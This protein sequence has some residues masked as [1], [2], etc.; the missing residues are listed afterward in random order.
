MLRRTFLYNKFM[1][2][3]IMSRKIA[4]VILAILLVATLLSP[5]AVAAGTDANT[6]VQSV[7]FHAQWLP[8][9]S[10][11]L[12]SVFIYPLDADASA[13]VGGDCGKCSR[14]IYPSEYWGLPAGNFVVLPYA[15]FN[16]FWGWVQCNVTGQHFSHDITLPT[17]WW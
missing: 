14:F 11:T 6:P 3:F 8:C 15:C 10:L 17:P 4:S 9:K 2:V 1:E 5:V 13:S 16:F 12:V 7:D